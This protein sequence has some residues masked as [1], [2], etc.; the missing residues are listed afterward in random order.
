MNPKLATRPDE[1]NPD[2]FPDNPTQQYTKVRY[3][4]CIVYDP[5]K[6]R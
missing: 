3:L 5:F 4:L 2:F 6:N 1:D